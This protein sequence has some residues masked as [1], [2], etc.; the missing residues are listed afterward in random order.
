M[1]WPIPP[2]VLREHVPSQ[3][4]IDT[5]AG[6]AWISIV[7]FAVSDLRLRWLPRIPFYN[8]MLEVNVRTYVTYNRNQGTYFFSLDADKLAVVLGAKILT[9]PYKKAK[10]CMKAGNQVNFFSKRQ[11]LNKNSAT[12]Q[13]VYHPLNTAST[14][15]SPGTLTHWLIER[16]RLWTTRGRALYQGDIHHKMWNLSPAAAKIKTQTLTDFLPDK[17]LK[18]APLLHYSP[19]QRALIWPLRKV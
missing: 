9:L 3:L 2:E 16:Y 11:G 7:G 10:M 4:E 14:P 1:H 19:V 17:F 13:G 18:Q 6:N 15:A 8:T 12:F 5:F